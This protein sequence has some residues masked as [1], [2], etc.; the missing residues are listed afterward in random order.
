ML[1]CAVLGVPG[2]GGAG[3]AVDIP[4]F[5]FLPQIFVFVFP[6]LC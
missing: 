4:A 1:V 3:G 5:I 6:G 2:W